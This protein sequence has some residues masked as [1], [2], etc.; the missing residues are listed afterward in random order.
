MPADR[1]ASPCVL[2]VDDDADLREAMAELIRDVGYRVDTAEDGRHA[3][4]HMHDCRPCLVL[5]D[6]MMPA[7]NGWQVIDAMRSDPSL[8]RVPVCVVSALPRSAPSDVVCVLA[9]PVSRDALLRAIADV[10]APPTR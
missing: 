2:V 4:S 3:L 8:Y 9:K 6:L 5:L 1:N 10:C 7:M